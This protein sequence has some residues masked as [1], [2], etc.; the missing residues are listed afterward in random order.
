MEFGK[1]AKDICTANRQG[2]DDAN[3]FWVPGNVSVL[4]LRLVLSYWLLS[5]RCVDQCYSCSR[6]CHVPPCLG[7]LYDN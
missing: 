5:K 3:L 2:L 4:F 7:I 6:H 1:L